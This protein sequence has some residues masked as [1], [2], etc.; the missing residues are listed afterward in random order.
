MESLNNISILEQLQNTRIMPPYDIPPHQFL[1]TWNDIPCFAKGELVAITGKAKSGKTYLNSILMAAATGKPIVH[2][3]R[4]DD[5]PYRVL[6][7]DTEQSE[8]STCEILRDR[9]GTL[10]GAIP[11]EE[12]Y[13]TY[14]LRSFDYKTREQLAFAA[15]L[16]TKPD[17]VIFDGIRDIVADINNYDEAQNIIGKLLSVASYSNACV[18]CVLHQNKAV[19][20]K[21]MRGAIGSELLNKSYECYS[22]T[23]NEAKIFSVKQIATRKYDITNPVQFTITPE[24]IPIECAVVE[25]EENIDVQEVFES[26]LQGTEM[27]A[28]TMKNIIRAKHKITESEYGALIGEALRLGIIS[29][30]V[31]SDREVYYKLKDKNED[32]NTQIGA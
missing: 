25:E 7:I 4:I 30:R 31:V 26:L 3:K 5:K 29:K 23:K 18:V 17:L 27:R 32:T 1:F 11:N 16:H 20:D 19:D 24:G 28:M 2:L 13:Y 21:S 9:I 6:W 15:I 14:N 22:T 12:L 8:D 10:I